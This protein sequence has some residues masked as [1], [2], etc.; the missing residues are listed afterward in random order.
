MRL[1]IKLG[2]VIL[3]TAL[4]GAAA[5]PVAAQKAADTLR[6]TMRDALPNVDPY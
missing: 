1:Q 5:A 6:I 4:L 3:A 2:T